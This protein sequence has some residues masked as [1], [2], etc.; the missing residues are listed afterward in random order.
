LATASEKGTLIRIFCTKTTKKIKEFR[1]GLDSTKIYSMDFDYFDNWIVCVCQ[2][3][4]VH[5]F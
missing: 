3:G 2:T 4:S 5:I 1:R